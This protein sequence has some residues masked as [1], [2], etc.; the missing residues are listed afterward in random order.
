MGLTGL[1]SGGC[2]AAVLGTAPMATGQAVEAVETGERVE[3]VEPLMLDWSM[4]KVSAGH[5]FVE[6][7]AVAPDGRVFFTDIPDREILIYDPATA[8]TSVFS[9]D[10][11][12]ANGL[13]FFADAL[14]VCEGGRGLISRYTNLSDAA[15]R[16]V[17]L[18]TYEGKSF[19]SP[20]DLAVTPDG[21]IHFTDPRYGNRED[22]T[23]DVEAV[24]TWLP[25]ENIVV[26]QGVFERPN[27]I[28]AASVAAS[29]EEAAGAYRIWVADHAAAEIHLWDFAQGARVASEETLF[30]VIDP[31]RGGV[32][33]MWF[34][35]E[36]RLYCTVPQ[37][38]LVV[39][40]DESG[41]ELGRLA[42]PEGPA[43]VVLTSDG[44]KMYVT[45]R[46]GL[47]EVDVDWDE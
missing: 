8:E 46:T 30:A 1:I 13:F 37:M 3:V 32:D 39:I 18:E 38:N 47:Y 14:Y 36:R 6:G 5:R 44:T 9:D 33:G 34:D 11:G 7:P 22:M 25:D 20:N 26:Q 2:L 4:R 29:D 45:A 35:A 31:E 17:L 10:S 23:L 43:N 40:F 28:V 27:G 19:N 24:Y 42:F 21:A 15:S 41:A 12:R 16:E